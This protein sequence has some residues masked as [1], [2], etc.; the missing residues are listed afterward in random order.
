[1]ERAAI[2]TRYEDEIG[3]WGTYWDFGPDWHGDE[4]EAEAHKVLE[5]WVALRPHVEALAGAGDAEAV[6][7]LSEG[8]GLAADAQGYLADEEN[9]E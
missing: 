1:M 7:S 4:G 8:D 5:S 6:I 3:E 2:V 9:G